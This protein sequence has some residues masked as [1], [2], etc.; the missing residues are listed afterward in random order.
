MTRYLTFCVGGID[1]KL[2]NYTLQFLKG[3]KTKDLVVQAKDDNIVEIN[4]AYNLF[5]VVENFKTLPHLRYGENRTTT[6]IITS[7]DS[8]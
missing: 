4:E 3:E 8:K 2:Q 7:D 1:Y 5:I 6:I